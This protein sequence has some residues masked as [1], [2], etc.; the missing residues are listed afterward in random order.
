MAYDAF[1]SYSHAADGVLAPAL[2]HGLERLARPV[3]PA[4][5]DGRVPGPVRPR[6]DA[7]PV[8][9]HRHQA[10][11][12]AVPGG[13]RLP[14]VGGLGVGQQGGLALV[15]H[16]GHRAAAAR[17]DRR[18]DR[19]GRRRPTTSP[20]GRRPSC[21]RS[22]GASRRS[23]C[24]T[25]CAGRATRRTSPSTCPASGARSRSS[26]RPSAASRPTTSRA[27]TSGSTGGPVAWPRPRWRSWSCSPSWPRRRRSP[28]CATRSAPTVGPGRP[29]PARSGC[30]PSTNR[31][32]RSTA[33]CSCRWPPR[34]STRT[35]APTASARAACSSGA[36]PAS[37][38]SSPHPPPPAR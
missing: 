36:T 32:A 23:R 22:E 29:S 9:H 6:P 38:P 14:G 30:R 7:P 18:R 27:R 15:R 11:P 35:P 20:P 33:P 13:P 1:I 34:G 37:T 8:E 16:P 2:E 25:T 31:P 4:A 17:R 26:P 3:V 24:T 28:R 19:L 21:P 12:V 5:G 10:G